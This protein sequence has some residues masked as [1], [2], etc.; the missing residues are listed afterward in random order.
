MVPSDSLNSPTPAGMHGMSFSD[1]ENRTSSSL[2]PAAPFVEQ[3]LKAPKP[4]CWSFP[5][6][7]GCSER[8]FAPSAWLPVAGSPFE[9]QSSWPTPSL[10]RLTSIRTRS[11]CCS[12]LTA[13]LTPAVGNSMQQA[14]CSILGLAL[15]P[16][17]WISAPLQGSCALPA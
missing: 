17:V 10:P 15:S 1:R 9:D 2:L 4:A 8:P 14:R 3:R 16:G 5:T 12:F 11:A 13:R 6:G 7:T